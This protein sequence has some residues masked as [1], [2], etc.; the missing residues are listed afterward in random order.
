MSTA[1][2]PTRVFM[3]DGFDATAFDAEKK[4]KEHN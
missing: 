1:L 4:K 3:K 2:R